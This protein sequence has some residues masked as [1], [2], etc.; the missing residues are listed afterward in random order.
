M[1]IRSGISHELVERAHLEFQSAESK[2][3]SAMQ[4][5]REVD[6]PNYAAVFVDAQRSIERSTK[7]IFKLMDVQHG[8]DHQISPE[9][10]RGCNL[11]NS[12][13][14]EVLD[15]NYPI[16]GEWGLTKQEIADI[17]TQE[18]AR[19]LFL[20]EMYGNMYPISD[21]GIDE[22]NFQMPANKFIKSGEEE[23]I[24]ESAV[25]GLRIADAVIDSIA[26]G[27]MPRTGR[28]SGPE[29]PMEEL[30]GI[31]GTHY[32]VGKQMT[33]ADPVSEYRRK[34]E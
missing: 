17:H 28:P 10:E 9:S 23:V 30:S 31:K 8:T 29:G 18:V 1:G 6:N 21:Y 33:D 34:L 19:I 2:F 3:D 27:E 24:I 25:T 12:I 14:H 5:R 11:L 15:I 20:C 32:G 16:Q 22:P 7:S 26:T 4:F 13:K